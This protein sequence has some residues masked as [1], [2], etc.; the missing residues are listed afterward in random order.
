MSIGYALEAYF[1]RRRLESTVDPLPDLCLLVA[2]AI[3]SPLAGQWEPVPILRSDE[4]GI[5]VHF[6]ILT[7]FRVIYIHDKKR[8]NLQLTVS[9]IDDVFFSQDHKNARKGTPNF[10]MSVLGA[11]RFFQWVQFSSEMQEHRK[12]KYKTLHNTKLY[13]AHSCES[14]VGTSGY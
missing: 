9:R 14:T 4:I 3:L 2:S 6:E 13:S 12:Y 7:L 1:Q 10:A 11:R 5:F 8:L